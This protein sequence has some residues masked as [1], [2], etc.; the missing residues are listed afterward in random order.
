MS[1]SMFTF[2][3]VSVG[4]G[5]FGAAVTTYL[6][7][8]FDTTSDTTKI[9]LYPDVLIPEIRTGVS[10]ERS[11]RVESKSTVKNN[12][13]SEAP[14]TASTRHAEATFICFMPIESVAKRKAVKPSVRYIT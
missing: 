4:S 5:L 3:L 6:N 2:A 13:H 8:V 12:M 7:C 14:T 11:V 10:I 9:P 1:T